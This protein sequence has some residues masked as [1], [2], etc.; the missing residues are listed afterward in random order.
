MNSTPPDLSPV[1][2]VGCSL[3]GRSWRFRSTDT[4]LGMAIS[5][6]LN[7]PEIMGRV[8]AG[9]GVGLDQAESYLNPV[10]QNDLPDPSGLV[11]M[12]LA[13]ERFVSAIASRE[14][15]AIFGDYDVDGATSS[16]LLQ[17][18]LNQIGQPVIL[19]VP[20]R[21]TEGYG[22]NGPALTALAKRGARLVI[23]VDCGTMAFAALAE[24]RQAGLDVIVV[25]HHL[26]EATLPEAY[27]V[28]N[29]NRLDDTSGQGVL[30]AVGVAFLLL[31]AVN[32]ALRARGWF[33]Q[34]GFAEPNLMKLLDLVALGTVCD[35]ASLTGVNRAL[36]RQ[37]LK[38][39][40]QR[41]NPGIRALADVAGNDTDPTVY[42]AGFIFGPRINAGGRVGKSDLGARLLASND[43]S[44]IT[45]IAAE[46]HHLNRE[47]QSIEA[48]V[49][50]EALAQAET[51]RGDGGL[52]LV[53]GHGWHPGVIGI[54]ASRLKDRYNLPCLVIGIDAAGIGKASGR[55]ITGVDLGAAV[56][57]ARQAGLLITG[58]GH[59]MAAGLTVTAAKI[60][61][62][63]A[64]LNERLAPQVASAGTAGSVGL[65]GILAA[66]AATIELIDTLQLAGPYGAGNPE[67]RFAFPD[68]RVVDARIVGADHVSCVLVTGDGGRLSGI[69][70]R[71]VQTPLGQALLA[72]PRSGPLHVAGKLRADSWRGV[73]RVQLH[74]DDASYAK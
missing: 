3:T 46:L 20:D 68:A 72:G 56:T 37:G 1:L 25:D 14:S 66:G 50:E 15:I 71:S 10:L 11:D 61:E 49:L 4:R 59:K 21:M 40:A 73:R 69:A 36:V 62:L 70:F 23:T 12:D 17:R 52:L 51:K 38:V 74:V 13:A 5:Q 60:P 54:V 58:G 42:H 43:S 48:Q 41:L 30:A 34:N 39:M 27:A 35:V 16:A 2:G 44:E 26:A 6:R 65:D 64:F 57:S 45:V 22:P 8:L 33:A 28:V 67:P 9:R 24:G 53:A 19:Y 47:R 18:Y 29:P 7:L 55:S 63:Q 31:V 32:R